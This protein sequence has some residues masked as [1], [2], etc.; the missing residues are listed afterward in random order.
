MNGSKRSAA[1]K[2]IVPVAT[3]FFLMS[4]TPPV[5]VTP[6]STD[7][8]AEISSVGLDV[9]SPSGPAY[10][11]TPVAG[12]ARG[13]LIG[14]GHAGLCCLYLFADVDPRVFAAGVL[15]APPA[16]VG[17]AIYGAVN[18]PSAESV[19][20][21]HTSL[22][23]ATDETNVAML[24]RD[25]LLSPPDPATDVSLAPVGLQH[26]PAFDHL[27]EIEVS[28]PTFTS[29]GKFQPD[30]TLF[31]E[32]RARLRRVNDHASLYEGR[33]LYR[34]FTRPYFDLAADDAVLLRTDMHVAATRL[35]DKIRVDLF[36]PGESDVVRAPMP[37]EA[38]ALPKVSERDLLSEVLSLPH[39]P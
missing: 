9:T 35:A 3:V 7:V 33:W 22:K 29:D 34:G 25:R 18:A 4:C 12:K 32:A 10:I 19:N 6:P 5:R 37:G 28:S 36:A 2:Q 20:T 17:G 27:L 21:A 11:E 23:K 8:R 24:L 26:S 15:L 31:V 30:V 1:R 14:A 13:A 38:V 16:A 39:C